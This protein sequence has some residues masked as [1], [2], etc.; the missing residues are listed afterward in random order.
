LRCFWGRRSDNFFNFFK[1]ISA[2]QTIIEKN[3]TPQISGFSDALIG[4][5]LGG[6]FGAFFTFLFFLL[7]EHI[8]RKIK[9]N[10]KV[11][12][13]HAYL[14]RYFGDLRLTIDL[15]KTLLSMIIEDF[16]SK[17][18]NI[19][20]LSP[21]PI[22]YDST[23]KMKDTIFINKIE[24]FFSSLKVL[25]LDLNNLN[26]FKEKINEDLLNSS[27]D[28]RKRGEGI[29]KN[30]LS[31][32]EKCL[33]ALKYSLNEID[34]LFAENRILLKKYKNWDYKKKK[35]DEEYKKRKVLIKNEIDLMDDE[36]ENNPIINDH[37]EKLRKFGFLND[38]VDKTTKTDT[39]SD[40][41]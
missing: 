23:M 4:A 18:I 41:F 1:D 7:Q 19:M 32:A 11:K 39:H 35:I 31:E 29:V 28:I 21:V 38:P 30:F 33:K 25:N 37:K 8:K 22:R 2:I 9:W 10:S 15:N 40:N 13:E 5:F 36:I 6:F 17:K 24:I 34:E 3:A 14:E 27:E 20:N 16:K 26:Y 12:V